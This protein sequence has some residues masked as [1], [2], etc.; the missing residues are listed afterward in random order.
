MESEFLFSGKSILFS[1]S[2]FFFLRKPLLALKSVSTSRN[3]GFSWNIVSTWRKKNYHWQE[4]LNSRE[5][6][7]S[8]T[9][10]ISCP[11]AIIS[12]FF[13]NCFLPIPIMASTSRKIALIKKALFPLDRK[14][15]STSRMKNLLK[16][17][18]P[19]YGKVASTLKILKSLK[20][21]KKL[22]L[23]IKK[24][25]QKFHHVKYYDGKWKQTF[26]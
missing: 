13:E 26:C 2:F 10:K 9:Q 5:K 21:S 11:L 12:C 14:S 16:Y 19:L 20:I 24:Y 22:V 18:F 17:A 25:N 8:A 15:V 1:K 6:M 4:S 7:V 3:K 23:P